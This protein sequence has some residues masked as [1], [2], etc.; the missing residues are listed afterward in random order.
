M[1]AVFY[2]F[3][4]L[5]DYTAADEDFTVVK[6]DGLSRCYGTLF[7]LEYDFGQAAVSQWAYFTFTFAVAVA[8]FRRRRER[9]CKI[10]LRDEVQI[11]RH[12]PLRERGAVFADDDAAVFYVKT[13]NIKRMGGGNA[14][15]FALTNGVE[16]YA[17]MAAEYIAFRIDDIARFEDM[18]RFGFDIRLIIV[19]RDKADFLTFRFMGDG[20]VEFFR[21]LAR[22]CFRVIAERQQKMFQCELV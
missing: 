17:F 18:R 21:Q 19:I 22:L 2:L 5:F 10:V 16:R 4:Y 9:S 1:I 6:D 11:L 8:D 13:C 7:F 3:Y 12:K 15:P 14:E 20:Q